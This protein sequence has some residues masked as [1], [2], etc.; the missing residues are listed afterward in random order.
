MAVNY[1]FV[2]LLFIVIIPPALANILK[3]LLPKSSDVNRMRVM[4][5]N[6]IPI[7]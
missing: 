4:A 6:I 3:Y 5:H 7:T 1:F 2:D